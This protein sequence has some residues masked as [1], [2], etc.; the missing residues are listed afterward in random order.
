MK[1]QTGN[2]RRR[3]VAKRKLKV[4][5]W[6]AL[7][8]VILWLPLVSPSAEQAAMGPAFSVVYDFRGQ[9]DGGSPTAGVIADSTSNLYG[10][11]VIGGAYGFGAVY[12]VLATE[13]EEVLYSFT[14][15]ADGA[16]PVASLLRNLYGTAEAGGTFN[17]ACPSGCGVVFQV[18]PQGKERVLYSFTGGADGNLPFAKLVKD[19][20]GN[21]YGTTTVGGDG[22]CVGYGGFGV[23]GCGVV[24]KIGKTG[25]GNGTAHL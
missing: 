21:L 4:P 17:D 9:P 2:E 22:S 19:S 12:E 18:T 13:G 20:E 6:A 16:D 5:V 1:D 8:A 3:L 25:G 23:I 11:T 7:A 14:G 24:F 10:T 15:G